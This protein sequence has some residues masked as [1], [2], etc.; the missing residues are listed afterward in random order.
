MKETLLYI[1]APKENEERGPLYAESAIAAIH[2]L[3]GADVPVSLEIGMG[4][5]SKI[6]FFVRAARGAVRLTE[7]QLYAQYPEIDIEYLKEDPFAVAEGEQVVSMDLVLTDPEVFPIKR[8]PQFDDM[9][10]RVNVDPIAGITSTLAHYSVPG[11]RGHVGIVIKPL[12]GSFRRRSLRFLPLLTKGLSSISVK[13]A[14]LF[15]RVQL[16]RGWKRLLYLPLAFFLGGFRA[17]PGVSKFA[18]KSLAAIESDS[19]D[20]DLQEEQQ[21]SMRSHDRE[22]SISAAADKVN[23]LMFTCNIR[24]SVI[25]PAGH[26]EEAKEKLKEIAGSFRQF[27]LPQCNAFGPRKIRSSDTVNH[28]FIEQPYILSVEEIATLWHMPTIL[29]QTPNIDWVVSKKLEPPNNLPLA[30]KEPDLTVLGEAVFRGQRHKFGIRPDDR[31]RHIYTIGKT[32]MG[33]STILENMIYSDI[34]SGKGIAVIDPHGDLIDDILRFIPKERSNDVILFDPSDTDFPL[35]FNVLDCADKDQRVLVASGLMSVFTKLWPDAF[36]GR[37]EHILR[38]TL[39]AL[40]EAE[41]QSMLGIMRIFADDSYRAKIVEKVSDPMVKSF[42]EDEYASWSDKYRTEAI[43]AIQNKVGQ[44]LSTPLIRNIV[45]QVKSRLD[46]RHA[47]DTGKIILVNLSKGKLGEDSSAFIG[48]MLV[49]KFQIDAMSRA[50]IPEEERK[51]FYLYVDEFQNFATESFATILS[52][53]RKY[54]LNLTMANQ[55]VAQLLIGDNST[56]LRDAVFGNVGTMISFQVGSDDAEVLSLQFEETVTPKDILSLPKY[57]AYARLMV[58]GM[59]NLPFSVSTLPPPEF[60]QDA[61]RVDL[62][63]KLSRERYAE[64]REVVEDKINKW[65]AQAAEGK[66]EAKKD[67]KAKEKADDELK[68]ARKKGMK[69][70]EYRAWRDREMWLNDFNMLRKQDLLEANLDDAQ[71]KEMAELTKK[72]ETSGGVPEISKTLQAEIDK[73][74]A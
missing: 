54:R 30:D 32:G 58:N 14:Q 21:A 40:L 55:Y 15:T 37:M 62:I 36:S 63:R 38:N 31:R 41:G 70:E 20:P 72:L 35:S 48:S 29:V 52:E 51:D 13:H 71:K 23:R 24:I 26:E 19:Y 16:A 3:K 61:G 57:H 18:G 11:M 10:T 25:A 45:G 69:I 12:T 60:E 68:K 44:L 65:S 33:K 34:H 17:W 64:K 49:T 6:G 47:M 1:R 28:G 4:H 43:A 5:D 46:V 2:S 53:A 56:K 39:L 66:N 27:A 22:D 8:H 59:T 67:A 42:W 50:D 74:K 7:S 9:L 73:K